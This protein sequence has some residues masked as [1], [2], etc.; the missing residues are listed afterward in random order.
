[1][2]RKI[3][4]SWLFS[5]LPLV[6]AALE[7]V[8]AAPQDGATVPLL[9][10]AQKAFVTLP[11]AERIAFF[12]D[13][14]KRKQLVKDAGWLPLPVGFAWTSDAPDGTTFRVLISESQVH[15]VP[16]SGARNNNLCH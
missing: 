5:I 16:P 10:A 13:A 6:L 7:I 15:N 1:M 4:F 8:S 2:K 12:A 9:N 14:E 11:R 3:L